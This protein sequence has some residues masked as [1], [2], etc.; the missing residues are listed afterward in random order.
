[1][2]RFALSI[3]ALALFA[4]TLTGCHAEGHTD[5][6]SGGSVDIGH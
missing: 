4:A 3:L 5:N 2:I 6:G 1:M